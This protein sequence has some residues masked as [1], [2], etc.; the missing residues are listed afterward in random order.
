VGAKFFGHVQTGPGSH[1]ASCTMSTR[2]FLGVKQPGRDADPTPPTTDEGTKGPVQAC[3]GTASPF[4]ER[5]TEGYI[6]HNAQ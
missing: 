4:T 2:S 3:N 1:P 5:C 6:E